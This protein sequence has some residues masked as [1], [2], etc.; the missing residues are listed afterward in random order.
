MDDILTK[1]KKKNGE[2]SYLFWKGI[3]SVDFIWIELLTGTI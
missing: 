3:R 2:I 1:K